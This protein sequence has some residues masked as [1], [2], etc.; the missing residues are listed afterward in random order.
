MIAQF[1]IIPIGRDESL[2]AFVAEMIKIVEKSGLDYQLTAMGTIVEGEWDEVMDL[3][4]YCRTR[5]LKMA[6]RILIN[7]TI[8]ERP[9]KPRN[10][11]TAKVE[12]VQR[13]LGKRQRSE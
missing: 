8:D 12:A 9:A 10:R 7:I 13:R 5:A 6:S 1:S 2:S 3:F 11:L 4:R